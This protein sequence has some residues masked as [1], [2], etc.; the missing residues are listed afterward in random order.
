MG[1]I[2]DYSDLIRLIPVSNQSAMVKKLEG[3]EL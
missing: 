1:S 2:K 3:P